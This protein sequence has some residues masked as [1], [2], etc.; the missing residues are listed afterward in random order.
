[1]VL[2]QEIASIIKF[3][4]DSTGNP[5]PYYYKVPQSFTVPAA[6]FPPPE[7]NTD[8]ETLTAYGMDYTMY[9]KFFA[10]SSEEA[11]QYG[12]KAVTTIRGR[13]NL[14][15]LIQEDGKPQP[16]RGL[17]INDPSLKMLD[18]GAAQVTVNWRSRRPYD[19]EAV[20]KMMTY[21][22]E[23]WHNPD[24][25][26]SHTITA[27]MEAALEQYAISYPADKKAGEYPEK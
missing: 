10:L 8:G 3:L 9:V 25:Y 1:M 7:I 13:R 5:S 6:Y 24:V 20:Q 26:V 22:V 11:Y 2:E 15:P 4:L 21:E 12:L 27:A 19:D 18:D 17:R 14:V 23:G 16:G